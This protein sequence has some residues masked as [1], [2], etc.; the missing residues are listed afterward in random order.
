MNSST[1]ALEIKIKDTMHRLA[2]TSRCSYTESKLTFTFIHTDSV[3]ASSVLRPVVPN[4]TYI[5]EP[6]VNNLFAPVIIFASESEAPQLLSIIEPLGEA[7]DSVAVVIF[8]TSNKRFSSE[9]VLC[10]S[11]AMHETTTKIDKDLSEEIV[12]S[13]APKMVRWLNSCSS[14]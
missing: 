4:E 10:T 14:K 8:T 7:L 1:V 3:R 11:M 5:E 12:L 13:I 2:N 6:N 9:K